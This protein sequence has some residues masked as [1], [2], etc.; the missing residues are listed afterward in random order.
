M[1]PMDRA[2][3]FSNHDAIFLDLDGTLFD[4]RLLAVY[5]FRRALADLERTHDL[6]LPA[7]TDAELLA[8]VGHP[9]ADQARTIL[10]RDL[11][12]H[13]PWLRRRVQEHEEEFIR[14][15]EAGL[16][17]GSRRLLTQLR[18]QGFRTF[19]ASNCSV[20]YRDLVLGRFDLFSFFDG[21]YCIGMFAG[22]T[23]TEMVG[24][25]IAKE[26]VKGGFMVGDRSSDMEAGMSNGLATVACRYGFGRPEELACADF[27]VDSV[28]DLSRLLYRRNL[29]ME[30]AARLILDAAH[31]ALAG[32]HHFVVAVTGPD[33]AGK[34]TWAEALAE[35]LQESS[36]PT[37]VV[38]L[39]DFH[40]PSEIRGGGNLPPPEAYYRQ[41]FD[42]QRLRDQVLGPISSGARRLE[43]DVFDLERDTVTRLEQ[44]DLDGPTIVILEGVFLLRPEVSDAIDYSLV[45]ECDDSTVLER[46]SRRDEYLFG[47][48]EQIRERYLAKYLPGQRIYEA[49]CA[50]SARANSVIDHNNP[51]WPRIIRW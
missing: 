17:E 7:V 47:S 12:A 9:G 42:W 19:L 46:A 36:T 44:R 51:G 4:T 18:D 23:K 33:A 5:A 39:D 2:G 31:A 50:P 13:S 43:W 6:K 25:I 32:G 35:R 3:L 24:E 45:L 22:G 30:D 34:T 20:R 41:G 38:H 37:V 10:P 48:E 21:P 8:T 29:V 26:N 1:E 40:H 28:A 11:A 49:L 16:F 27:S 15:G 14:S